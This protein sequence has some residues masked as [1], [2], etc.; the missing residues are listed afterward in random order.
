MILNLIAHA[1]LKKQENRY[2]K[3]KKNG[4]EDK[5]SFF[6]APKLLNMWLNK[7]ENVKGCFDVQA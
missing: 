4:V 1:P 3:K 2:S 7:G 5:D 6:V